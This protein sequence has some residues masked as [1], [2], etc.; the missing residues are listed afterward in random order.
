MEFQD[1]FFKYHWTDGGSGICSQ[2]HTILAYS[3]NNC[4]SCLF[5]VCWEDI[6]WPENI[7]IPNFFWIWFCL[8]GNYLTKLPKLKPIGICVS[9]SVLLLDFF[10]FLIKNLLVLEAKFELVIK[11]FCNQKIFFKSRK[12]VYELGNEFC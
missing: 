11:D 12:S 6:L 4:C 10:L 8:W 3:T 1:F 9:I 7:L 5:Y 2:N